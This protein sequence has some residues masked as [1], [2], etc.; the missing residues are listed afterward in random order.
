[1]Q[2]FGQDVVDGDADV[3]P[4]ERNDSCSGRDDIAIEIAPAEVGGRINGRTSVDFDLPV[5]EV[6]DPVVRQF[7]PRVSATLVNAIELEA[8][9]GNLHDEYG[10]RRMVDEIV[11]RATRGDRDVRLRLGLL[12]QRDGVLLNVFGSAT[13]MWPSMSSTGSSSRR[14]PSSSSL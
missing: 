9:L 3:W 10:T 13:M 4:R 7:P 11:A 1:V 8:G 2:R 14:T 5:R 12:V 6:H